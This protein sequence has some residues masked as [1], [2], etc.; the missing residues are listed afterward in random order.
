MSAVGM[1][2]VAAVAQALLMTFLMSL[3]AILSMRGA[4]RAF[5]RMQ[6]HRQSRGLRVAQGAARLGF[7]ISLAAAVVSGGLLLVGIVAF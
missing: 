7:G 6:Q 1:G 5:G 2:A 3:V 4:S